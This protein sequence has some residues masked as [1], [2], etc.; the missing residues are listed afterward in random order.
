MDV[1]TKPSVQ[2]L[3]RGVELVVM[4]ELLVRMNLTISAESKKKLAQI[5]RSLNWEVS[6]TKKFIGKDSL[7]WTRVN[8]AKNQELFI[9]KLELLSER[10]EKDLKAIDDLLSKGFS[11]E[12]C[13]VYLRT[14]YGAT[15]DIILDTDEEEEEALEFSNNVVCNLNLSNYYKHI[16]TIIEALAYTYYV[17]YNFPHKTELPTYIKK[18][19]YIKVA[20]DL[21][22]NSDLEIEW[23]MLSMKKGFIDLIN[24]LNDEEYKIFKKY[25]LKKFIS[26]ETIDKF[27]LFTFD[28]R[29]YGA[30]CKTCRYIDSNKEPPKLIGISTKLSKKIIEYAHKVKQEVGSS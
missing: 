1:L 22:K 5:L 28:R 24:R 7:V 3:L 21:D 27:N 26:R 23:K 6:G 30:L 14:L 20:L 13:L 4:D 9:R 12:E 2:R 19:R 29:T 10:Q 11:R 18:E 16:L 8:D 25:C 15:I 17:E